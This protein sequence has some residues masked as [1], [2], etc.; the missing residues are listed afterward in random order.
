MVVTE[1]SIDNVGNA[2]DGQIAQ[3]AGG[4]VGGQVTQCRGSDRDRHGCKKS[5]GRGRV[6]GLPEEMLKISGYE[7]AGATV[8][9]AKEGP[10]RGRRERGEVVGEGSLSAWRSWTGGYWGAPDRGCKR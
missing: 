5:R 1:L 3:T 7:R 2:G 10:Y 8:A 4:T 6:A 9:T